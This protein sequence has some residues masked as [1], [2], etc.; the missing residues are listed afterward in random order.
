HMRGIRC[1]RSDE[2]LIRKQDWGCITLE[3]RDQIE[4]ERYEA[5]VLRYTFRGGESGPEF[6]ARFTLFAKQV[7]DELNRSSYPE[8]VA[9]ITHGF[10]VRT[11][12]M[13][14]LG[15]SEEYFE[16]LAHPDNCGYKRLE[17]RQDGSL[18]LLD[19]M[20]QHNLMAQHG[21][22]GRKTS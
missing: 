14:L 12:L 22:V 16:S 8:H 18:V 7:K 4:R 19:P 6:V 5:G 13:V 21:F 20:S 10:G 11:L 2:P 9:V 17:I 15:W 3:N 1:S